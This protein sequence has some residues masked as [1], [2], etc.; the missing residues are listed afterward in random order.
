LSQ[1]Q[2]VRVVNLVF[3]EMAAALK[4]GSAVEFPFGR[5]KRVKRVSKRWQHM[6]DEPMQPYTVER[7]L[8]CS[9]KSGAERVGAYPFSS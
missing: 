8:G 4:R 5:L 1:R 3:A 2:A 9:R 6:D 7:E